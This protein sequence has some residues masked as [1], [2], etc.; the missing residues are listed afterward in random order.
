MELDGEISHFGLKAVQAQIM[1]ASHKTS[2]LCSH[3]IS[4]MIP[5]WPKWFLIALIEHGPSDSLRGTALVQM[6]ILDRLSSFLD[7]WPVQ[8]IDRI[9]RS[10]ISTW[11]IDY[12]G[13]N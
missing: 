11:M 6:E 13:S 12:V 10:Y 2:I 3:G 4:F 9:P 5:S 8:Y 7:L 1:H